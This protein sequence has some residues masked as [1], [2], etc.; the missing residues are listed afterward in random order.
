MVQE[1]SSILVFVG[2]LIG[3]FKKISSNLRFTD[4]EKERKDELLEG[5]ERFDD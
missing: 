3:N 1:P 2:I 4:L 5:V